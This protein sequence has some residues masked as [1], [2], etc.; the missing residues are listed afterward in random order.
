MSV[1]AS[2][3]PDLIK[4]ELGKM[5]LHYAAVMPNLAAQKKLEPIKNA[6]QNSH[7]VRIHQ[8]V[9]YW[10]AVQECLKQ[11]ALP[12]GIVDV[13]FNFVDTA[14]K[15]TYNPLMICTWQS[16]VCARVRGNLTGYPPCAIEFLNG[17]DS[18]RDDIDTEMLSER[19]KLSYEINTTFIDE[20]WVEQVVYP[21]LQ[22]IKDWVT[23]FT[24]LCYDNNGQ[25]F[26]LAFFF[27]TFSELEANDHVIEFGWRMNVPSEKAVEAIQWLKMHNID[28]NLLTGEI[29]LE[30]YDTQ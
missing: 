9:E 18:H 6:T 25:F 22:Q 23:L 13:I 17:C 19:E 30:Q 29:N 28:I 8:S 24:A 1:N 10:P 7:F 5:C 16:D 4:D 15:K 11:R 3:M 21:V 2:C 14:G 27:T 20:I 26:I 12:Q